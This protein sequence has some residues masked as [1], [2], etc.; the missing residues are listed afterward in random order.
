MVANLKI[1][2]STGNQGIQNCT[3]LKTKMTAQQ[4][5]PLFA[6]YGDCDQTWFLSSS[7]KFFYR[8]NKHEKN[9][10]VD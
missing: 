8:R 5:P 9:Y 3:A 4:G 1:D 2:S 7:H 10:K 6:Q